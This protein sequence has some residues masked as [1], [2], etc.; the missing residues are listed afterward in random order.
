MSRQ[1]RSPLLRVRKRSRRTIPVPEMLEDRTLLSFGFLT[2]FPLPAHTGQPAAA[3]SKPWD[4]T[5]GPD[6]NLWFTEQDPTYGNRLGRITTSGAIT[7][8]SQGISHEAWPTGIAADPIDDR[9]YFT[10]YRG[11]RLGWIDTS[12]KDISELPLKT[13]DSFPAE[14]FFVQPQNLFISQSRS[15]TFANVNIFAQ[16]TFDSPPQGLAPITSKSTPWGMASDKNDYF[17]F[18]E[19]SAGRIG[20]YG[21]DTSSGLGKTWE[22]ETPREMAGK[23]SQPQ[24][25]VEAPD[26]SLWYTDY[27]AGVIGKITPFDTNTDTVTIHEY[28]LAPGSEPWGIV[29][30]PGGYLYF[31]EYG[32]NAIGQIDTQNGQ[33]E[34][35]HLPHAD[36]GPRGI[37]V[38]STGA[39]W[40]TESDG[41]RIGRYLF[42]SFN[43]AVNFPVSPNFL[44]DSIAVAD[45]NGDGKPDLATSNFYSF[46]GYPSVS[47]LLNTTPAGASAPSFANQHPVFG[48]VKALDVAVGD[49]NGDGKPDLAVAGYYQGHGAVAVLLNTTPKG[50]LTVSFAKPAI[51]KFSS[52]AIP[53]WVAVADFNGD[54]KPDLAVAMHGLSSKAVSVLLNMTPI[55]S[56]TPAFAPAQSFRTRGDNNSVA[57]ADFNGDGKPDLVVTNYDSHN[58]QVLLNTTPARSSTASFTSPPKT[59]SLGAAPF[60]VVTGDFNSDGKPDIAVAQA[61]VNYVSV[62]LNQTVKGRLEPGFAH[63]QR[64]KI[65]R[66]P[67]NGRQEFAQEFIAVGDFNGGG[68]PDLAAISSSSVSVL[69]NTTPVNAAA[70]SFAK[71]QTVGGMP[72][73]QSVATGDF[74]QDR[75][76][77]IVV[78]NETGKAAALSVLLN[79]T[80]QG[81][82][83]AQR[84]GPIASYLGDAFSRLTGQTLS[85]Q[86]LYDLSKTVGLTA[87]SAPA[88]HPPPPRP[89]RGRQPRVRHSP[90][91]QPLH[92]F[93]RPPRLAVRARKRARL[94]AARPHRTRARGRAARL[95]PA[96]PTARR[97]H[98]RW[99]H[100]GRLFRHPPPPRQPGPDRFR[101]QAARA[102]RAAGGRRGGPGEERRG[103][104]G[105]GRLLVPHV[106][107]TAPRPARSRA[108][109][110]PA[111]RGVH[112]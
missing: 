58:V 109:G 67:G 97:Q 107:G 39:I 110:P 51:L 28:L 30:G 38:D 48:K 61:N 6:G 95:H 94:S 36:S 18:T 76:L 47:V 33:I 81:E 29:A 75:K 50:A 46:S 32:G 91:S 88:V 31:T 14:P 85:D 43:K 8:F 64:F 37:T 111:S 7:E 40:F 65:K 15:N 59:L 41:N 49:F 83:P 72:G 77:D 87:A 92:G 71:E 99:F 68:K 104:R 89:R 79:T 100:P 35:D 105:G 112:H 25:I 13:A 98:S 52:G 80:P 22:F 74:N 78:A 63:E 108:P 19:S 90:G 45:F 44:H 55:G 70:A 101:G 56:P 96:L 26:G 62:F 23:P 27:A 24:S 34:I 53:F 66:V 11:N 106:A 5:L 84:S 42:L 86:R 17:Y 82:T 3:S 2:E 16:P 4:I 21:I 10:E 73:L 103:D 69:V 20:V 102:R 1:H 12:S 57:V 93:V 60:Y 54:G 9:V